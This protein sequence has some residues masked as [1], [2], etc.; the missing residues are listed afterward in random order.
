MTRAAH[1]EGARK[2]TEERMAKVLVCI[3]KTCLRMLLVVL[4]FVPRKKRK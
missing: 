4:G 1:S 3:L 2:R